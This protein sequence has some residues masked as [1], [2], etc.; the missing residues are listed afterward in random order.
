MRQ[1]LAAHLDAS[2]GARACELDG[3]AQEIYKH[4]LYE[5]GVTLN[6]WQ[7]F[8]PPLDLAAFDAL[9]EFLDDVGHQQ[10]QGYG[11][12]F[13]I[14]ATEA[15]KIQQVVNQVSHAFGATLDA[16]KVALGFLGKFGGKISPQDL[17]KTMNMTQRGT[18][19]VGNRIT[20]R[21]Q[22]SIQGFQPLHLFVD[23]VT[24]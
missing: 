17:G 21:F 7:S 5:R 2:V 20:E 9:T 6:I 13:D 4:L 12:A 14:T 16:R 11:L 8:H 18:Q 15:G 10:A 23:L 3:I 24:G 22:I 1:R 19:I